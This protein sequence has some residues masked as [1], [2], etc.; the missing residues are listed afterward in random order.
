MFNRLENYPYYLP[1][2]WREKAGV[3]GEDILSTPTSILPPAY[4]QAGI[5]G[6]DNTCKFSL[7]EGEEP[8]LKDCQDDQK[9]EIG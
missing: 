4:R 8:V 9:R 6:E 7:F 2:S 5:K 3:R 1:L